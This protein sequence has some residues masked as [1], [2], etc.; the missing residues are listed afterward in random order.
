ME[1]PGPGAYNKEEVKQDY[2]YVPMQRY[3]PNYFFKQSTNPKHSDRTSFIPKR[4]APP[5][6]VY[7]QDFY[8]I[9]KK[10]AKH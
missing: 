9:S 5:I 8:D 6:G 7:D 10:V 4:N 2:E 1:T 3:D